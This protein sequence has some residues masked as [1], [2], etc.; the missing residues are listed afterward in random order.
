[1]DTNENRVSPLE[2]KFKAL[3]KEIPIPSYIW[4][5]VQ[6]NLILID[7]NIAAEEIT[8]GEIKDSLGIKASKMYKDQPEILEELNRCGT[9]HVNIVRE[10]QYNLNSRSEKSFLFIKSIFIPPDLVIAHIKNISKYK[11]AE[12]QLKECSRN[13]IERKQAEEELRKAKT[14][15]ESIIDSLPGIFYFFNEKG[16]FLRWNKN[17]EE[18]SEYSSEEILRMSMLDF[19]KGEDKKIMTERIHEVFIEGNS[20]AE[21]DFISKSGKKNPYYFTGL[22]IMIGNIP[23]LGGM[24]IN[25]T[26]RKQAEEEL[27]KSEEKY[28][29]AFNRANLY[30]DL[31]AHDMNNILQ[32]ILL[33]IE[34]LS[35]YQKEPEKRKEI[36]ELLS[37]AIIQVGRGKKLISNVTY[38]TKIEEIEISIKS[39]EVYEVLEK[40]IEYIN[41]SFQ[42]R[43]INI[44]I[45]SNSKEFYIK[46]NELLPEVFENILINAVIHNKNP[47]VEILIKI[48]K[49]Q[50]NG[51]TFLKLEFID[52]GIGIRDI[53]KEKIFLRITKINKKAPG[54]GLGLSLVKKIIEKYY[55]K[56]W[57]EDKIQG[58]YTKGSNFVVLI[59]LA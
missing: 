44:K 30:K 48:S 18:V 45:D 2:K 10:I 46:A 3:F 13:N 22:L 29:E 37:T 50:E 42:D 7:Y 43:R 14:F 21:A 9:D 32:N 23:Y 54:M 31:L 55:G 17:F 56:I 34:L 51:I 53:M 6:N 49:Y 38:I 8:K 28:H 59:L 26:E 39:I 4:Q 5:K 24:G 41:K 47:S 15:S 58:D 52:N 1:M 12:E 16:K 36:E 33:S 40:T 27:R 35:L 20:T 19:F 57:V 25:I 11:Q